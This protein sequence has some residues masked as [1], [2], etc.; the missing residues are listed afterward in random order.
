TL[1]APDL[2]ALLCSRV[3]HDIISPV[4]AINNGLELLD[5]GGADEDAMALIR[6]SARTAS[7]RLQ[8][9]RIA[10]GAAGSAGMQI[11]TGDAASVAAAF[12]ANEK[13][14]LEWNGARALL[15][16]NEVKLL[17]NLVMVAAGA[18]P[19]GGRLA[20]DLADL[21]T[22]PRFTIKAT[23]PMVRVPPKFLEMHSGTKPEE[24]I[25]AHAVQPYYTL[26][27]AREAGRTISIRATADDVTLTV[28]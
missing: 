12:F 11:D 10:F 19:R 21:E 1:S 23:G 24:P 27:L 28:A 14:E 25:D 15:P 16:K 6:Q 2:A 13:P 18:I 9:A 22:S 26:L 20:V 17:L 4:G 7:A 5:E 8:F 3:C